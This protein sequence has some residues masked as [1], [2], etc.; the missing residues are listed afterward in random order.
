[1]N[2]NDHD[3]F[4]LYELMYLLRGDACLSLGKGK[5]CTARRMLVGR[6][7]NGERMGE[8]WDDLIELSC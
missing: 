6:I 1:M 8:E 4:D 3:N 7:G 2:D 5:K